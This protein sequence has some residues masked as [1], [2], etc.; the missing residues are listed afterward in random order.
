MPSRAP[1]ALAALRRLAALGL[2][3]R[4]AFPEFVRLLSEV[5]PFDTASM[6]WLDADHQPIDAYVSVENRP[7][8]SARYGMRWFNADEGQFYPTQAQMQTDPALGVIRVSD[9][10]RD[11]G[12]TEIYDEVYR[13]SRHH[14]IAGLALHDGLRPIGNLGLGR[15][16]GVADFSDEEVRRL[17]VVRPYIVQALSRRETPPPWP[18]DDMEDATAFLVA[19]LQGRIVHA[20]AGAWRLLQG[21]SG[22]PATPDILYD[23]AQAW[24]QPL[25][26]QLAGRVASAL[27]GAGGGPARMDT[28]TPYGRFVVRAYALDGDA[29][30][31]AQAVGV[32]LEKRVPA[33]LKMLRSP[34]FRALTPREQDVAQMLGE[35]HTY[36]QIAGRLGLGPSTVVTHVRNLGQ[37]LGVG[38][39]EDIVSALC[40]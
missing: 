12:E 11:F 6:L 16:P 4:L 27:E 22:Q 18:E 39:R 19:D 33:P 32:Q 8:L 26:L 15:P 40:A 24:A 9:F 37:K 25:L 23:R 38:G 3:N 36:P 13:P 21:A 10:T 7:E 35:G 20:S 28:V 5:A 1:S 34:L 17:K 14:W 30:G 2:S 31:G 29:D